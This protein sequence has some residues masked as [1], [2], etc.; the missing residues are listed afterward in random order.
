MRVHSLV[1]IRVYKTACHTHC[2][3]L[4]CCGLCVQN[5]F[6]VTLNAVYVKIYT[7]L[8]MRKRA[9]RRQMLSESSVNASPP[10]VQPVTTASKQDWC[11]SRG[12]CGARDRNCTGSND[13]SST[14]PFLRPGSCRSEA[15]DRSC[16]PPLEVYPGETKTPGMNRWMLLVAKKVAAVATAT[17]MCTIQPWIQP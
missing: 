4:H 7:S 14:G 9:G 17:T 6:S 2:N 12:R 3:A 10:H 11:A 1:Y 13:A 8:S 5:G 16:R 15:T